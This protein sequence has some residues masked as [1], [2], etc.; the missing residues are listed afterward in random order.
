MVRVLSGFFCL[1]AALSLHG[2]SRN[3]DIYFIDT[4]GGAATLIVSP[5]GQALLAD[6]GNATPDDRDAK[7]IAEA[8][9]LAGLTKIDAVITSHYH[10]DHA[11]GLNALA[12]MIPIEKYYDHG[13]SVEAST[14]NGA[15][16]W[17]TYKA[18][19][20]TK[21]TVVK[22]G[23]KIP[24]KGVDILVVSSN[25]EVLA[26][27]VNGGGPNGLCKDAQQK[28]PDPGEDDRS[29]GFLLTYGKFTFLDLGDLRW[30]KEM[31]LGCPV[32]KLGTVTLFQATHH[33]FVRDTSG[34]PAQVWALKPQVIVAENGAKKGFSAAGYETMAKV[35]GVQGIWVLHKAVDNDDSHNPRDP[36]IANIAEGDDGHWIKV[37]ASE[38]ARFTV[39]NGRNQFSGTYSAR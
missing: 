23:D 19:A 26:K 11:G 1:A 14:P 37:S 28:P 29:V 32:N 39:T 18:V 10:G 20:G 9:K 4:E 2:Q 33:G 36:M 27:P 24:L 22:P 15:K 12:R 17:D 16:A 31:E 34:P 13:E 25:G 35:P 6:S 7:R 38:D 30:D 3:L 21:R 8:A 5:S